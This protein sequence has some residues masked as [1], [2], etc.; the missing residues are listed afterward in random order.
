MVLRSI[1]HWKPVI[2]FY[3]IWQ[4]KFLENLEQVCL[5]FL[6]LLPVKTSANIK[7]YIFFRPCLYL[8]TWQEIKDS[9][10]REHPSFNSLHYSG[11][12]GK[13]RCC[14]K[15]PVIRQ[16]CLCTVAPSHSSV[17]FTVKSSFVF[18]HDNGWYPAWWQLIVSLQFEKLIWATGSMAVSRCVNVQEESRRWA[19]VRPEQDLSVYL[20]TDSSCVR[21][22]TLCVA[23]WEAG[24]LCLWLVSYS[25]KATT[26]NQSRNTTLRQLAPQWGRFFCIRPLCVVKYYLRANKMRY[27]GCFGNEA[28]EN[29]QPGSK[30]A[31]KGPAVLRWGRCL[32]ICPHGNDFTLW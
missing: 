12:S 19:G 4:Y 23:L 14:E 28:K 26:R 17:C 10:Q 8:H 22:L 1:C 30:L 16:S 11:A 2:V 18:Q 31:E 29:V 24:G 5:F 9:E 21:T 15:P 32:H 3:Y 13:L 6:F 20:L 27:C 25:L 7:W